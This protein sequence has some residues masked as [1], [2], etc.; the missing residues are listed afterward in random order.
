MSFPFVFFTQ[1][2]SPMVEVQI[3]ILCNR[4]LRNV[5]TFTLV[6]GLF[7]RWIVGSQPRRCNGFV[8]F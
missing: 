4:L 6:H 1:C 3:K 8:K 5:V 7:F 2:D